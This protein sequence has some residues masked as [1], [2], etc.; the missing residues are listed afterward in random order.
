MEALNPHVIYSGIL[1]NAA[2]TDSGHRN[3]LITEYEHGDGI[4]G[5]DG[6]DEPLPC[7]PHEF[8]KTLCKAVLR[9][10]RSPF[11]EV[12]AVPHFDRSSPCLSSVHQNTPHLPLVFPL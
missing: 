1:E 6:I 2:A 11:I 8:A 3:S 7:E 10:P 9:L 5:I 4:D 12:A